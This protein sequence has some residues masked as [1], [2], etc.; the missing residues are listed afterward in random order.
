MGQAVVNKQPARVQNVVPQ[1]RL[2]MH[3]VLNIQASSWRVI[4]IAVLMTMVVASA[5]AVI[6]SSHW[7]RKQFNELQQLERQR[8]RLEVEWGQLLLEESTWSAHSRVETL[9][10][11]RLHMFSPPPKSIIMVQP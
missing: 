10:R 1:K 7:N 2:V 9:A 3:P 11:D 4:L 6:L 8:D 5:V